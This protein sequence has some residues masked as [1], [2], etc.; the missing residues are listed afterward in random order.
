MLKHPAGRLSLALSQRRS[1]RKG[2]HQKRTIRAPVD[3][4]I[5]VVVLNYV[6]L[7][8]SLT[9]PIVFN[10]GSHPGVRYVD[11]VGAGRDEHIPRE[12]VGS[13][14]VINAAEFTRL[15]RTLRKQHKRTSKQLPSVAALGNPPTG[16]YSMPANQEQATAHLRA[17]RELNDLAVLDNLRSPRDSA[18]ELHLAGKHRDAASNFY[19]YA[20]SA[21]G[22]A[23]AFVGPGGFYTLESFVINHNQ[24]RALLEIGNF[25][26]ASKLM[27]LHFGQWI[28]FAGMPVDRMGEVEFVGEAIQYLNGYLEAVS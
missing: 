8:L 14:R 7:V 13:Q 28:Y 19:H 17:S 1:Q 24:I 22:E 23:R 10:E 5:G 9:P 16:N 25:Q 26:L 4:T 18:L 2:G 20:T 27:D 3:N 12:F 6:C 21:D 11:R 15:D